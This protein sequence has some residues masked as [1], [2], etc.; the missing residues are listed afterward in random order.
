MRLKT[1]LFA[2]GPL[3]PIAGYPVAAH[4]PSH[5]SDLS[6]RVRTPRVILPSDAKQPFDPR[7][8]RVFRGAVHK[9]S[10]IQTGR[11][12]IQITGSGPK[13]EARLLQNPG[14]NLFCCGSEV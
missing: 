2:I 14:R 4:K 1:A 7:G 3:L 11:M 10:L 12:E 5:L 13:R 9:I 6:S 8:T